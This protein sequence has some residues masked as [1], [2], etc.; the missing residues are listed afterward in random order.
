MKRYRLAALTSSTSFRVFGKIGNIFP[1][2]DLSSLFRSNRALLNPPGKKR[3]APNHSLPATAQTASFS[4]PIQLQA[5][6]PPRKIVF[7]I[8]ALASS[9]RRNFKFASL[10]ALTAFSAQGAFAANWYVDGKYGNNKND[11]SRNAPVLSV[12]RA[13]SMASPGDTVYLQPTVTYGPIWLS[14]KSGTPGKNITLAGAG[15]GSN[16][17]KVTGARKNSGVML[18]KGRSYLTIRNLDVI[19]PGHG[20]YP[21]SAIHLLGNHHID[22]LNNYAHDAGCAGVQTTDSDYLRISGNRVANNSTDSTNNIFCSGISTHENLDIDNNKDTKIWITNN[23][24]YGNRNTRSPICIGSCLNS[25]GNGIIIDDSRRTQTDW[26]AYRGKTIIQNNVVAGNGG[27]GIHVYYSDN[28][29]VTANTVYKNNRDPKLGSWHPGEVMVISSG[30]VDVY[31]NILV[32]DGLYGSWATGN[33]VAVAVE[34]CW[35]GGK[36]NVDYNLLYTTNNNWSLRQYTRNVGVPL[37][38]GNN[39]RFGD[40]KFKNPGTDLTWADFRIKSGSP[41]QGVKS[42]WYTNPKKDF[43]GWKRGSPM[44]AGAYEIPVN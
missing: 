42:P 10:L 35:S 19:A 1:F 30:D 6:R 16:M 44:N 13:W 4:S 28:V 17:T 37:W 9:P 27:R 2:S 22:I 33:R 25:D 7:R 23:M 20:T 21:Y 5:L 18:E 11:G 41:A 34:D 36:I 3:R 26:R 24:V 29:V 14:G 31:N 40:P 15:T 32:S 43:L 38:M 8:P 12:W 39:N